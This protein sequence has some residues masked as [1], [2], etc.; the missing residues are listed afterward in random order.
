MI[1]TCAISSG[2]S[3]VRSIGSFSLA[4]GEQ[5][6][7]AKIKDTK[8]RFSRDPGLKVRDLRKHGQN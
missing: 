8:M 7:A 1:V 6:V 5:L 3:N 2:W 4:I